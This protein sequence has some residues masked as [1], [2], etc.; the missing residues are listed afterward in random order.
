MAGLR[1]SQLPV[2]TAVASA[3]V[4]PFSS[5]SGSET[6]KITA[7]VL[8]LA[9][10][11]L[12]LSVGPTQPSAPYNGQPWIDT[13]TNPPVLKVWNGATFTIVS[14]LPG[15]AIIT[16]PAATAPASPA[17]GQLWQDTSQ[18]PDELKMWDGSNWVRVD[19]QGITQ[20]AGDARYLRIVT[21]ASTY[22]ALS[23]GTLTGNLTLPGVPTT[24]NMAATK[25]Y[26]D[27]QIAGI[28]AATDLTP[29]GT[30]IYTAR[31]TA[32]TGYL[33]ANG[34]AISRTTYAT[35]FA[36]IGTLYGIGDGSTTFN[37]PDLRGEF[38]RGFDDGRGVD[39]GR[40]MGSNQAQNYQ[41]HNHLVS[42]PGHSHTYQ[43]AT[44]GQE[45]IEG[46][47]RAVQAYTENTSSQTTGI[48]IQN[49]GGTETRPRN[50]A[51]L[52]CIKT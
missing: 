3:D 35:L 42:D 50:I 16:N 1:I 8:G 40:T 49:N 14:F 37:L 24:T 33:K 26:V 46:S 25:G 9:L 5:V 43:S 19:P 28:P 21:A 4:F 51:L 12:G 18:T 44:S 39:T 45:V 30:V 31:T 20:T 6:R 36:A 2:G 17:L 22:L 7:A 27:T 11:Q 52:G 29:A 34:A 41:S 38:V 13:S 10:T 47:G 15:S 48:T 32:P 23:G